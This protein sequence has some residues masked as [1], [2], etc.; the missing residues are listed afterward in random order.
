[1]K[2]FKGRC[3]SLGTLIQITSLTDTQLENIAKLEIR[4]KLE[5]KAGLTEKMKR[6]LADL[7]Y[8]KANPELIDGAKTILREH[9]SYK[10]GLDRGK[11]FN[12][13]IQKGIM[14]EDESIELT[15]RVIFGEVGLVKNTEFKSN[16]F[17]EGTCD[18]QYEEW[19][20]DTKT[21]L[22]SK[23]FHEK[24]LTPPTIKQIWQLKGYGILYNKSKALLSHTL[25]N[26]PTWSHLKASFSGKPFE[27]IEYECTYEHIPEI[28]RVIGYEIPLESTDEIAI[29]K[30]I[31]MCR[32]YL[33]WY[34]SLIKEKIGNV[35]L[36]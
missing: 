14:M 23:T 25:V 22:D 19:V 7:R 30:G 6:D 8:K 21:A 12:E 20:I 3:S 4:E 15:D 31:T 36:T 24:V 34:D 11:I 26:T 10:I 28:E 5:G 18:I 9:Y 1:M 17:I 16:K 32:D 2:Q 29:E 13:S 33:V 35:N 27:Q